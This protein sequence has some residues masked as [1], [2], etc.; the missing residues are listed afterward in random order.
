M[1]VYSY[2]RTN[3]Q[4]LQS[5]G[6]TQT[7]VIFS[8][9]LDCQMKVKGTLWLQELTIK[10]A[11]VGFCLGFRVNKTNSTTGKQKNNNNQTNTNNNSNS[12]DSYHSIC[13]EPHLH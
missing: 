7:I 2:I 9:S 3:I 12:N 11:G 5:G 13:A 8:A 6:S 1:C 4:L 10:L